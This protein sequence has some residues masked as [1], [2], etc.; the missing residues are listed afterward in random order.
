MS[1]IVDLPPDVEVRLQQEAT[2]QGVPASD[3]ALRL[4][5]DNLPPAAPPQEKAAPVLT[6]KQKAALALLEEWR[7]EYEAADEED[8]A[9]REIALQEFAANMNANRALEGRAPVFP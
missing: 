1:F 7:A 3:V 2:R 9:A 4:V 6:E 8:L 5:S